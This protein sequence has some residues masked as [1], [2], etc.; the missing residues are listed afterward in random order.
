MQGQFLDSTA[1][2]FDNDYYKQLL[3]VKGVFFSDQSLVGDHMTKWF[4]EAFAKDQGLIFKEF[5]ASMLKLGN[6]RGSRNGEELIA[7]WQTE[8]DSEQKPICPG[9]CFL[10]HRF[11]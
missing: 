4:V 8:R 11:S 3:A 1:L 6:L 2:V 9:F 5:T 7:G 10:S